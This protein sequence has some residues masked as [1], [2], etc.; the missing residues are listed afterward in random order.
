[1]KLKFT[2][3][4]SLLV[5]IGFVPWMVQGQSG[6]GGG[7]F[8]GSGSENGRTSDLVRR[9]DSNGNNM[10][11]P[12]ESQGPGGFILQRLAQNNPKIDLTKPIPID[13]LITEMDGKTTVDETAVSKKN[14]GNQSQSGAPGGM[15]GGMGGMGGMRGG[16]MMGGMGGMGG[17]GMGGMGGMGGGGMGGGGMGGGGMGGGGMGGGLGGMGGGGMGGMGYGGMGGMGGGMGGMGYGFEI[18][19]WQKPVG[20]EPAWLA[21]GRKSIKLQEELRD[22]LNEEIEVDFPKLALVELVDYMSDKL[23]IQT[24]INLP[25]IQDEALEADSEIAPVRKFS[26]PV[27]DFL[28]RTLEPFKL[29]YRVHENYIEIT[30]TNMAE[31]YPIIRYY[32]LSYVL[33]NNSLLNDLINTIQSSIEPDSWVSNGGT[34]SIVPIGNLLV[35]STTETNHLEIERLLAQLARRSQP[36]NDSASVEKKQPPATVADTFGAEDAGSTE[37]IR[38]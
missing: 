5:I 11:D 8:Q 9:L 33:D 6:G 32:D 21:N 38:K 10:I 4:S 7:G 28:R 27:R 15:G 12:D 17:G 29:T 35:I 30:S 14:D 16:G 34:S 37:A 31:S 13:V 18:Q 1:M 25:A 20:R 19:Q 3:L 24:Q 26:G 22:R 36:S 2:I 23:E